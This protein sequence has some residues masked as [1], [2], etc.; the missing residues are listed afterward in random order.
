MKGGKRDRSSLFPLGNAIQECETFEV[1]KNSGET[2]D[3]PTG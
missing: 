3:L 2:D 1:V